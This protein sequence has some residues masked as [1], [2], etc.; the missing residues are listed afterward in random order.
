VRPIRDRYPLRVRTT[1]LESARIPYAET[2]EE[3][4]DQDDS[5]H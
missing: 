5:G 4:T 1:V 3:S 2:V